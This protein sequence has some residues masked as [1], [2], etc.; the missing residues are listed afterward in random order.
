[1]RT[2]GLVK[3]YTDSI[4]GA[5]VYRPRGMVARMYL[6][7]KDLRERPSEIVA[8]E[9]GHAAMAWARLRGANLRRM[10]GEEVMCYALG[11]LVSHVNRCCYAAGVW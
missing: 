9:C 8:H 3:H 6:N 5:F 7:T 11:R 2:M 10:P 4:T 1:M